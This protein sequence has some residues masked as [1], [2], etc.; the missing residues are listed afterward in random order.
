MGI[1]KNCKNL[2]A[3]DLMAELKEIRTTKL[4]HYHTTA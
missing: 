4:M 2:K 1:L 3:G